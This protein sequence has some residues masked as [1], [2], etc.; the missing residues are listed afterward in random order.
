MNVTQDIILVRFVN[1]AKNVLIIVV[2]VLKINIMFVGVNLVL[3]KKIEGILLIVD[4]MKDML[5][6]YL[7]KLNLI[8]VHLVLKAVLLVD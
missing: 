4:V 1:H 5:I 6:G 7:E 8:I 3:V 2:L